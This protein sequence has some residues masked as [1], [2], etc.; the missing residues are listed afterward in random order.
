MILYLPDTRTHT[1]EK[2]SNCQVIKEKREGGRSGRQEGQR[3]QTCRR[4][5]VHHCPNLLPPLLHRIHQQHLCIYL[6]LSYPLK[7]YMQNSKLLPLFSRF[8][9][10]CFSLVAIHCGAQRSLSERGPT[11][12]VIGRVQSV[13]VQ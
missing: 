2:K 10:I 3:I 1:S 4:S 12:D 13:A 5:Q 8:L 9:F 11:G 6:A 7:L